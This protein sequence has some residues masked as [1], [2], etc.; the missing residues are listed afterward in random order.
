MWSEGAIPRHWFVQAHLAALW[1]QVDR[2]QLNWLTRLILGDIRAR[3]H[4]RH[5]SWELARPALGPS[6]LYRV[7]VSSGVAGRYAWAAKR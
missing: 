4:Q 5:A 3:F 2:L 1:Q 6:T 7:N